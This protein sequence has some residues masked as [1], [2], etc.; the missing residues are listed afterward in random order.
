MHIVIMKH[1]ILV[2]FFSLI[3]IKADEKPV[4]RF[5]PELTEIELDAQA[6]V[7]VRVDSVRS[8]MGFSA[9][10]SYDSETVRVLRV[11]EGTMFTSP[12][13]FAAFI[14]SVEGTIKVES[15]LLGGGRKVDGSGLLFSI[16][17]FGKAEGTDTLSFF[18]VNLRD[19]DREKIEPVAKNG[20]LIIGKPGSVEFPGTI[21]YSYRLFQ[22]FPN[23]FNPVTNIQ[24]YLPHVST[25][26]IRLYNTKGQEIQ[27]LLNGKVLQPGYHMIKINA[28]GLPGGVYYYRF[29]AQP[30]DGRQSF[31]KGKRMVLLK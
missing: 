20:I 30:V 31:I 12:T 7:D 18:D 17:V 28:A 27:R 25:V 21:P 29:E 5:S 15:A 4:L 3:S 10:V 13:F 8:M 2:I 24:F 9:Q 1:I 26:S 23:P 14:D 11:R 6:V 22:N 16:D 19:V